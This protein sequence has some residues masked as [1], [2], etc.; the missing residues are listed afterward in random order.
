M[1]INLNTQQYTSDVVRVDAGLPIKAHLVSNSIGN[2][3]CLAIQPDPG[4]LNIFKSAVKTWQ[5]YVDWLIW[6]VASVI[7]GYVLTVLKKNIQKRL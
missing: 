7:L 1:G 4:A 2:V 6:S 5:F 3:D